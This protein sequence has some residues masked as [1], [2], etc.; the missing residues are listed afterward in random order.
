MFIAHECLVCLV[1]QAAEAGRF[2]EFPPASR[3]ALIRSTLR[4][5]AQCPWEI[6]APEIAAETQEFLRNLSQNDD[7]YRDLKEA[8]AAVA[9]ALLPRWQGLLRTAGEPLPLALRLSAAGNLIDCGPTGSLD[10]AEIESRIDAVISREWSGVDLP[11]LESGLGKARTLLLI[12]DNVGELTADRL[13]L[14]VIERRF[15]H[16]RISVLVR[17]GPVLNDATPEDATRCGFP[18]HWQLLDSRVRIPGLPLHRCPQAV[19]DLFFSSDLIIAKGQGNWE[20]LDTTPHPD[21]F[22]LLTCKCPSVAKTLGTVVGAPVLRRSRFH[23]EG[24]ASRAEDGGSG[25]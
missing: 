2:L 24:S 14:E 12:A 15:P 5:L 9:E 23:A 25:R 7:P 10:L 22:F 21:L 16:L 3:E 6:T 1:R 4:H 20:T 13:L 8:S 11:A 17:G 18:S 19:S